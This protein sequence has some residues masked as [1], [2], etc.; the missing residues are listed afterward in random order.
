V[1]GQRQGR[2]PRRDP[3]NVRGSLVDEDDAERLAVAD[4]R[5]TALATMGLGA[6]MVLMAVVVLVTAV[7]LDNGGTLV[8]PATA[9]YVIGVLLLVTGGLM[10]A[11][12]RRDMGVWEYSDHTD[13]QD[14]LRAAALLGV[15]VAFA[16]LMPLVGYVGAAT[17][18]FGTSAV[19]LGAPDRV[20]AYLYG[21]IVATVVFLLFDG[22][23][24]I[25]LPAGPWGF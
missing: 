4:D 25:T 20:R 6:V 11:R 8:G 22:L 3:L 24:G 14:W 1:S 16:V 21:F 19:V 10:V 18:L 9:P 5:R 13:R 2:T 12:G 17:L 15:L 7:G 23:I